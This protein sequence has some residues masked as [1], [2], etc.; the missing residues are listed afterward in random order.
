M[1]DYDVNKV[2]YVKRKVMRSKYGR[3]N[4]VEEEGRAGIEQPSSM[5][6]PGG[7]IDCG[8]DEVKKE[9]SQGDGPNENN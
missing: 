6:Q 3:L 1:D 7:V 5:E 8:G 4:I 9:K 2:E